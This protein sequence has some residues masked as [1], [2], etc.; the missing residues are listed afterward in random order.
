MVTL[1][2]HFGHSYTHFDPNFDAS[3]VEILSTAD[4]GIFLHS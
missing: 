1:V 2:G 3:T 4:C